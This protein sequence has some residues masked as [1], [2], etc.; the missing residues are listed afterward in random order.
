MVSNNRCF[1]IGGGPSVK[2]IDFTP[3][4]HEFIIGVN[5]AFRLGTWIDLWFFADSDIFKTHKKEIET[6][7]NRIASCAGAAKGHKKIEYYYR[8][9][10]HVLCT[11]YNKL[12]F[13]ARGANSGATA[14][15]LA[16]REGFEQIILFGFDMQV[17][18]GK[19]NFH[20]Y[21]QKQPRPDAYD[22]FT[23]V[24]EEIAK[25]ATVEIINANPNSA[26]NCFPKK[27]II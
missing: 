26:L 16:I 1:I 15:N 25:E 5:E 3:I 21:Y 2:D 7:P 4:K 24:I 22:R 19:H 17:V 12:S 9:R 13:P 11:E 20:D 10:E 8:C 6:W 18:D 27:K 23:E 14:I